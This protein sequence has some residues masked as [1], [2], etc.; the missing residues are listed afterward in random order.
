MKYR[1]CE[2]VQVHLG[3]EEDQPEHVNQG[4]RH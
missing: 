4:A 1:N 2:G 3:V